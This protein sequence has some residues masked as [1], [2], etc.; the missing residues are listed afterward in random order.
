MKILLAA[1]F[2]LLTSFVCA[3]DQTVLEM[4]DLGL[5]ITHPKTWQVT[6]VKKTNDLRVLMPV[7]GSSEKALLELFN[8]SFNSEKEIWQLSQK[9]IND[10]M[11]HEIMRQ[12]EEELLGVPMLLTKVSFT[13]KEGPHILLTGLIYSRTPQ[14]LMFRLE[15]SPDDYDKAEFSWR[16]VMNSFRTGAPWQP[17]DP[18]RKPDPKNPKGGKGNISLPP[19]VITKPKNLDGD[20]KIA[21]PPV[22]IEATIANRKVLIKVPNEWAG[23]VNE[24]GSL[25]LTNPEIAGQ[26]RLSLATSLDSDPPQRALLVA[27]SKTLGEFAKVAKRDETVPAQNKA[28]AQAASVWRAGTTASGDLFTCDAVVFNGDYYAV[29]GYRTLN[30]SK[31]GGER[32]TIE[33]LLQMMTIEVAP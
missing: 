30:A 16:E 7:E 3:Q 1:T 28:G 6:P 22:S 9:G 10:R 18:N 21:K 31:I 8:I 33:N 15:A 17:E 27:S 24:D 25:T 2:A 19:P 32:R 5:A 13:D 14:K 29:V 12:W 20:A 4:P 23:K 26:V 11:K